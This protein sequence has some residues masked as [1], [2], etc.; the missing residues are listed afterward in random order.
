MYFRQLEK[1]R[2]DARAPPLRPLAGEQVA[3]NFY[4]FDHFPAQFFLGD[5]LHRLRDELE[6]GVV[7]DLELHLVP[8]VWKK[9]PR[10]IVNEFVE[11]LF[12]WELDQTTAR[13]ITGYVFAAEF[14]QGSVEISDVDHVPCGITD[15]YP[16]TDPERLA[17]KDINPGEEA[18]HRGLYSQPDDDRT[19]TER[20][21]GSVPIHENDRDDNHGD[22]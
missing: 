22:A 12:G 2:V 9:C 20:S 1:S 13:V 11:H 17:N 8:D 14:P 7:S 19:N 6:V 16:I 10:E 21:D 5:F 18:L 15:L 3:I 4:A